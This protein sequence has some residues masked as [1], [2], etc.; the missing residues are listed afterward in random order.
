MTE[1]VRYDP[2]DH[3]IALD[4]HPTWRRGATKRRCTATTSTTSGR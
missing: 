1:P 2:Y 4:P 3:A